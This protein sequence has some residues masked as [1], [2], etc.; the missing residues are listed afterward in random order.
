MK[1]ISIILISLLSFSFQSTPH[2]TQLSIHVSNFENDQGQAILYVFSTKEGFPSKSEYAIK[3]I[4]TTIKN[5][6]AYFSINDLAAGKYAFFIF[7]DENMNEKLDRNFF[8]MPIEGG[9]VSN[10]EK[11]SFGPPSYNDSKFSLKE[12]VN[13]RMNVKMKYLM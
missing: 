5:G 1:S 11:G 3:R 2:R 9:G 6:A 8:G 4:K 7:H 12:N 10:Y 13:T